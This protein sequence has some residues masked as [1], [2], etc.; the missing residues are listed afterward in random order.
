MGATL[1]VL[2]SWLVV[3][4]VGAIT[5]TQ[6]LGWTGSRLIAVAQALTPYLAVAVVAVALLALRHGRLTLVTA[7][8]AVA[9]GIAVLGTPLAVPDRQPSAAPN[10]SGLDVAA[11]NLWYQNVRVDDIGDALADVDADVIVFT[12]YTPE[13]EAVLLS[14]PLATGYEH[15]YGTSGPRAD[16]IVA[17][18]RFPLRAGGADVVPR[19]LD[20]IVDGPDGD[21]RI[22]A[23]HLM[24]P[25]DDFTAWREGLST[26]ADIGRSTDEPTLLIGDLNSS[27]WHPDFRGLLDAGWVDANAATGSG[28]S[29]SW[30][31]NWWVPP[32]VRLDHALTAGDLVATS[33]DDLDVPG[34]DHRGLM[35]SVAPTR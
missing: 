9:F 5:L 6:A 32:F 29:T 3:G 16:G 35:V 30:P 31:T 12:E 10:S 19:G 23:M 13:H 20:L 26:A 24:T 4:L 1:V 2:G 21:I 28:F 17:W 33:V 34:S 8:T 7:A 14:G 27:Y 18:S 15:R 22:V 25:I 11:M